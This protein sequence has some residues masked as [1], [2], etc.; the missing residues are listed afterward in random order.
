LIDEKVRSKLAGEFGTDAAL[1][2]EREDL[3]EGVKK[4]TNE[5]GADGVV[6]NTG[7]L[8]HKP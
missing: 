4:M 5:V 6:E 1:G 7:S 8:L 3:L 2:V